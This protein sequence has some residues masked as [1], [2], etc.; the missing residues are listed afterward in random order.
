MHK[1]FIYAPIGGSLF[2]EGVNV[3]QISK[4]IASLKKGTDIELR[5][6]SPG[7]NAW[8]GVA[9]YNVLK[10]YEGKVT[11]YVDGLAASA[12][13]I[14]AM[15][16]DELVMGQGSQLM[17]HQASGVAI[18]NAEDMLATAEIL[19]TVTSEMI[20]IYEARTGL[21]EE[22]IKSMVYEE[23]WLDSEKAVSM[24]FADSKT[25]VKAVM[26]NEHVAFLK[27]Y[28][29][30]PAAL[31]KPEEDLLDEEPVKEDYS[32]LKAEYDGLF[33]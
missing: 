3:E 33:I 6:N 2:S 16:A 17:I 9:L 15:G 7:G 21:D 12:A 18:G 26:K 22:E 20:G 10:S 30:T 13:S 5:I 29:N 4:E 27:N 23:T 8:D 19:E 31:L 28:K 14:I 24:G 1:I 11:A 32:L 25:P